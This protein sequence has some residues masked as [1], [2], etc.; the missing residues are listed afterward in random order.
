MATK[1]AIARSG[2][3]RLVGSF[4][5]CVSTTGAVAVVSRLK[6]TTFPEY[7][8]KIIDTIR[9][10]WAYRPFLVNGHVAPVCTAVTFIYSQ[11]PPPPPPPA[12][13]TPTP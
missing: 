2:K 10:E 4:K 6:S 7:D 12:P 11:T 5:V 13:T 3:T 1:I 8:Q 9:N